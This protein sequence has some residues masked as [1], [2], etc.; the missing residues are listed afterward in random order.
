MAYTE[1]TLLKGFSRASV[2]PST[3]TGAFILNLL[4][5]QNF[6]R[7]TRLGTVLQVD[8][9]PTLDRYNVSRVF[10]LFGGGII[11]GPDPAQAAFGNSSEIWVRLFIPTLQYWV[12]S[13]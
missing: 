3:E 10:K 9:S 12:F 13:Q 4:P 7:L 8:P 1:G 6:D 11:A 5:N 2:I